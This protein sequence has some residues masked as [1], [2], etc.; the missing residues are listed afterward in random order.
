[1][2]VLFSGW[3]ESDSADSRTVHLTSAG[4]RHLLDG[5][6]RWNP[7]VY[8]RFPADLI[9]CPEKRFLLLERTGIDLVPLAER[10]AGIQKSRFAVGWEWG[11]T[12]DSAARLKQ[13][14]HW[15]YYFCSI[16]SRRPGPPKFCRIDATASCANN[17]AMYDLVDTM[18]F[19]KENRILLKL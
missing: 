7:T 19:T 1:M 6:G 2:Y 4:I 13:F 15:Y 18:L 16:S 17:D 10:A 9:V 11:G 14:N 5:I 8:S 3:N 12:G